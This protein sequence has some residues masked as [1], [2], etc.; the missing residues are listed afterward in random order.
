MNGL[1]GQ[2]SEGLAAVKE[3]AMV[4]VA[5][6]I[7]PGEVIIC[8]LVDTDARRLVTY[9]VSLVEEINR[10]IA[11]SNAEPPHRHNLEQGTVCPICLAASKLQVEVEQGEAIGNLIWPHIK[12]T[13]SE[14]D[15]VKV[16]QAPG[17]TALREGWKIVALP[18]RREAIGVADVIIVGG[19]PPG[20]DDLSDLLEQGGLFRPRT[21]SAGAI[22]AFLRTFGAYGGHRR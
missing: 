15:L 5:D 11:V 9:H 4:G 14:A 18:K 8:E 20:M 19:M 16:I 22:S 2:L 21:S 7:G 10:K 6:K 13:L 3:D 17:G 12:A 1:L